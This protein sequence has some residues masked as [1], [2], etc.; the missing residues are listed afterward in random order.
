VETAAT[1]I[2]LWRWN[3]PSAFAQVF[4]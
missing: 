4:C 1:M 3:G 2:A